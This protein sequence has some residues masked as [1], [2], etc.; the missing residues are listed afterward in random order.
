MLKAC[1]D[2]FKD[3]LDSLSQKDLAGCA[4]KVVR[5]KVAGAECGMNELADELQ[6]DIFGS[7]ASIRRNANQSML[8]ESSF[9]REHLI[10]RMM[11]CSRT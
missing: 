9:L 2:L 3:K 7:Y 8:G 4:M 5:P 6:R 10:A 11:R 1:I